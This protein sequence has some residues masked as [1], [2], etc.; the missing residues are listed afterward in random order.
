MA[1]PEQ[2]VIDIV[3]NN[4]SAI[5]ALERVKSKL[6]EIASLSG[7]IA[8]N[9]GKVGNFGNVNKNI[10]DTSK[11]INDTNKTLDDFQ[12]KIGNIYSLP[13]K[14]LVGQSDNSQKD[15]QNDINKTNKDLENLR[16]NAS[17]RIRVLIDSNNVKSTNEK[18]HQLNMM[19][20]KV[21][22]NAQKSFAGS[23]SGFQ[24]VGNPYSYYPPNFTT[25]G[26]PYD[27]TKLLGS[28][29]GKYGNN[30]LAQT[31]NSLDKIRKGFD[32]TSKS[33]SDF[34]KNANTVAQSASSYFHQFNN[35]LI[36]I[37]G[38]FTTLA[39]SIAGLFGAN[40]LGGMF[41]KMWKG[42]AD[43]QTNMLYLIHQKGVSQANAY[44]DEIMDIVTQLPGDDT[45][46]TNILNMSAAMDKNIKVDNLRELGTAITDFY[47]ASTMKGELPF[48]TE[49]DIRKYMTTGDTRGLRNSLL[50]SELDLLKDKNSVLERGQALQQA[51]ENTGF[52]GMSQYDSARNEL[53]EFKGH[54]QKAFADLGQSVI[55]VTQPLL[56][57]Y[58][59]ID[60]A[61]GSR[62][63]QMI[64]M[65][66]VA[67][68]GL[69]TV[70][71][72]GMI[73]T[74]VFFRIL[75]TVGMAMKMIV[76]ITKVA[77]STHSVFNAVL[78]V[79]LGLQ[80]EEIFASNVKV[81]TTIR[82]CAATLKNTL[83]NELYTASL[84]AEN[85]SL[86]G[87]ITAVGGYIKAK[88]IKILI[89][90]KELILGYSEVR[91]NEAEALMNKVLAGSE[92]NVAEAKKARRIMTINNIRVSIIARLESV[93]STIEN[94]INAASNIIHSKSNLIDATTE[95]IN[96]LAKES[97][98]IASIINSLSKINEMFTTLRLVGAILVA[99]VG[100]WLNTDATFAEAYAHV[101]N[102][103]AKVAETEATYGLATAIGILDILLAP[104]VL[105]I[106][107]I[108]GA[109]MALVIIVEKLGEAFGWWKDF[110]SMFQA[111]GDGINRIWNAFVNSDV[112]QGIIQYFGDF[113]ATIQ[114]VIKSIQDMFGALFGVS[115]T[116]SFDIV[117]TIIDMFGK[118]GDIVMW[119]WNLLDDWSNSP[120][121]IITWLNPLGI[122]L[123]H[124][125]ELGSFF[126]DVRDAI[127]RFVDTPEFQELIEAWNEAITALQEPFQEIWSL[128]NEIIGMFSDMFSDPEGQGTEERINFLVEILKG[129]AFLIKVTVIPAIKGIAF[130]LRIVLT[131][132]RVI[133]TVVKAIV[134]LFGN[135]NGSIDGV[136][137]SISNA[138]NPLNIINS[139]VEYIKWVVDS[140]VGALTSFFERDDVKK[141]T[142]PI[143]NY[144]KR[145]Y[146]LIVEWAKPFKPIIDWIIR[147]I[148]ALGTARI[149]AVLFGESWKLMVG[150]IEFVKNLI[151]SIG[152]IVTKVEDTIKNSFIGKALGW[153]KEDNKNDENDE[154][155]KNILTGS[156]DKIKGYVENANINP[157]MKNQM[158]GELNKQKL[159][160]GN[161]NDVKNL[162]S[163]YKNNNNQRQV[164]VNNNFSEGSMP[165]DARNMTKKEA[166]SMFIG[167][168]GY[169]RAV[170]Y[171]GILR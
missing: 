78:R 71:G 44:Y 72:T 168:F 40:S 13:H 64:I 45:F 86:W 25:V 50:A 23:G 26:M 131:P 18:V 94:L 138:L 67:L 93:K 103:A 121:G 1:N 158:L 63:S 154:N 167:A 153:D 89:T 3:V 21:R 106:M 48:E 42:A 145:G 113:I 30:P 27:P 73:I 116:G 56:K 51:L 146:D 149:Y 58:N 114:D 122:L 35:L 147:V 170:G 97:N 164:V 19:V 90:I 117:Q 129:L 99:T 132:L 16:K 7:K 120:L 36:T 162:G 108:V 20:D 34:G 68:I 109:V 38:Q 165:I 52:T 80:E 136:V 107:A 141:Y 91:L 76:L 41:E 110:G 84:N 82:E 10:N 5:G 60:T 28:G 118:L 123:F 95:E 69:F 111:I 53:E 88:L 66:A 59:A 119:V 11:S 14:T 101:L 144:L 55:A 139:V 157:L 87:V 150:P 83:A 127:D 104:E 31:S 171:N 29:E 74:S 4:S 151:A 134:G 24:L 77:T 6:D 61:F 57:F 79:T 156:I 130:A 161:V 125:D 159:T 92:V 155:K 37:G 85:I 163:T 135:L 9:I 49:R 98:T 105:L 126:E 169:R 148:N 39:T 142:V 15:V 65:V 62:V 115:D 2:V 46:L 137:Q 124:L 12:K 166:R 47:I 22:E 128:I 70:I 43:R 17:N 143:M 75:E 33:A 54:F 100:A 160:N 102:F 8:S 133:L 32:F 81:S 152:S 112:I 96:T 140:V